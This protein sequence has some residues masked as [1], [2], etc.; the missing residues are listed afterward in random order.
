MDDSAVASFFE[1][2]KDLKAAKERLITENNRLQQKLKDKDLQHEHELKQ[3]LREKDVRIGE[4]QQLLQNKDAKHD[5]LRKSFVKISQDF[6][7]AMDSEAGCEVQPH[8]VTDIATTNDEAISASS[9]S[10]KRVKSALPVVEPLKTS[11][12]K[13]PILQTSNSKASTLTTSNT[14]T[15][16]PKQSTPETSTPDSSRPEKELANLKRAIQALPW[17]TADDDPRDVLP[18][19][20]QPRAVKKGSMQTQGATAHKDGDQARAELQEWSMCFTVKLR[21]LLVSFSYQ[22]ATF[23]RGTIHSGY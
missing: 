21:Q 22:N 18:F 17:M 19:E 12:S 2:L 5:H 9:N 23:S 7:R 20:Q 4:L 10:A 11:T 15:S 6:T 1:G 8:R 3:Q 13:A 14:K 16:T